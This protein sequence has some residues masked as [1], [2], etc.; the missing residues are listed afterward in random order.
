MCI[1]YSARRASLRSAAD[2]EERQRDPQHVQGLDICIYMYICIMHLYIVR[3][4]EGVREERQRDPQH[5]QGPTTSR[6]RKYN[7]CNNTTITTSTTVTTSTTITTI[8]ARRAA[9]RS[10][11]CPGPS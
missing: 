6:K 9:T 5:V 8:I 10:S 3:E 4:S 1:A 11:T 2:R 7:I